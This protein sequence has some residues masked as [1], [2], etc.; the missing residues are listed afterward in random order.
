MPVSKTITNEEKV[1]ASLNITTSTGKPA[2]VD[3][4]PVW[5][6]VSGDSTVVPSADGLS[7]DLVSS[8][9]AGD[10]IFLVDADADLGSG[11]EDLQD[12]I[13]LT[14]KG[15]NAKNLGISLSDPVPK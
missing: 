8:D 1:N 9:N 4:P 11:V 15:A 6:V 7:A 3:G 10:T 12:T 14:V 2:K 13:T 5:S